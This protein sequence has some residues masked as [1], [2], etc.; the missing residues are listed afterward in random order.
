MT[1]RLS[2]PDQQCFVQ[3]A[4]HVADIDDA[5]EQWHALTRLGPFLVRRHIQLA[6]VRY[7]GR[8]ASLDISAA[9]VQSGSLQIELI[10]QHCDSPSA[11]RDM[12]AADEVGFHHVAIAPSDRTAMLDHYSSRGC[13]VVSEFDTIG[14]GG[15][16]Y[17][18][19]RS[20]LGHMVEIY[21][22]SDRI[23]KL[24]ELVASAAAEWDRRQLVIEL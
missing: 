5:I 2:S 7:R 24:Y 6:D 13:D 4:Y 3:N 17:V 15:A 20:T 1:L 12:F 22:V 18:D 23:S 14:G 10:Q 9:F 19:A 11:F 16:A 21:K 8:Q